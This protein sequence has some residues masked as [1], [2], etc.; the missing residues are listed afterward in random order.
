MEPRNIAPTDGGK[1]LCNNRGALGIQ[2]RYISYLHQ[3]NK[4]GWARAR[5][6][7]GS[8]DCYA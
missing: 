7:G 6:D 1:K 3:G 8:R 5:V 4:V 2:Q